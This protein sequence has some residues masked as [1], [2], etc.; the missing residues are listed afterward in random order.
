M[1]AAVYPFAQVLQGLRKQ[2]GL[3]ILQARDLTSY[4]NYERWESG[5]TR[6]GADHLH[7]I[8]AAFGVADDLWLLIYAWL[9]DR[10]SPLPGEDRIEVTGAALRTHIGNLPRE[11]IDLGEY[12]NLALAESTHSE[13]ALLGIAARY[14][15]GYA[16]SDRG[17]VLAATKRAAVP[18]STPGECSVLG[19]LYGDVL[20]DIYRYVGKTLMLGGLNRLSGRSQRQVQR[21]SLLLMAEPE[22][23]GQLLEVGVPPPGARL[24]GF[25]RL[26]ALAGRLRP[27]VERLGERQLEQIRRAEEESRGVPV[28]IDDVRT[29][30]REVAR[31]DALWDGPPPPC[32]EF[33]DLS[34]LPDADPEQTRRLRVLHDRA[35]RAARRAITEEL[36][37]ARNTADP[38]SA[39]DAL[40]LLEDDPPDN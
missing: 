31:D 29:S 25:A 4:A 18:A 19:H 27:Q 30:L 24:R 40:H 23:V 14:G 1:K 8:S 10:L 7:N 38:R 28:T 6:V 12:G 32:T 16:G 36:D 15:G 33:G 37:D 17:V 11:K 5:Q 39:V 3:S 22:T 35:D 34:A 26:A 20:R 13:L 9:V 21:Q 2:A